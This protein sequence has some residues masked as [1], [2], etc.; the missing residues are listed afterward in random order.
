MTLTT[1]I[2]TVFIKRL[3]TDAK[4]TIIVSA[5]FFYHTFNLFKSFIKK[6][7][8]IIGLVWRFAMIRVKIPKQLVN[9]SNQY[10][11]KNAESETQ[12]QVSYH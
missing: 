9:Y 1:R 8:Q 2:V 3:G 4:K 6:R 11:T 10:N 12:L 5:F 7:Y